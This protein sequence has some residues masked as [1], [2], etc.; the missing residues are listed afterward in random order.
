MKNKQTLK[1]RIGDYLEKE[2]LLEGGE[3]ILIGV[4]GGPDSMLLLRLLCEFREEKKLELIA[5]HI[6]HM[7]RGLQADREEDFVRDY[8]QKNE[9]IFRS[10]KIDVP[11]RMKRDKLSAQDA[12][13]LVRKEIFA[14]L[15]TE[16]GA[17]RLAL[18][19]H[20]DDRAETV[21]LHFLHGTGLR[22]L[23]ALPPRKDWLIRPLLELHKTEILAW[24]QE[25]RVPYCLDPS[26]NKT[27][28]RR[29]KIRHELLPLLH[30]YNPRIAEGLA[31]LAELAR[32][33][34][35]VLEFMTEK[36]WQEN[37]VC[38]QGDI[39]FTLES[40]AT[41]SKAIKRR[42]FRKA[43]RE[44]NGLHATLDYHH[45]EEL[46]RLSASESPGYLE[47]PLGSMC[48]KGYREL[49]I[50]K[51]KEELPEKREQFYLQ[52]KPGEKKEIPELGLSVVLSEEADLNDVHNKDFVLPLPR[53]LAEQGIILRNRR[54]GDMLRTSAGSKKLKKFLIDLK[55]PREE[56]DSL[57]MLARET[58]IFWIPKYF[59]ALELKENLTEKPYYLL[60]EQVEKN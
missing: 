13:H 21:L 52:I 59:S 10:Y 41:I 60:L 39:L 2:K 36:I 7:F 23:A 5:V 26:N 12:G 51:K 29:N 32:E 58:E 46:L 54:P 40:L 8:C 3:R 33:D 45:S 43:F 11:E 44:I 34:D 49:R 9:I 38:D 53:S 6:N 48:R 31:R 14:K 15:K 16:T 50:G 22:G 18:A 42:I 19:H 27:I 1:K 28:Y 24:C 4:S 37:A 30:E 55:I 17:N 47:L 20:L 57:L 56:R 35:E 25:L